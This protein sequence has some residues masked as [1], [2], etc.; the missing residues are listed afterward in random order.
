M[1]PMHRSIWFLTVLLSSLLS[2]GQSFGVA[3]D[4]APSGQAPSYLH[5]STT[6][7]IANAK[8]LASR[9][10][11]FETEI[12]QFS[13]HFFQFDPLWVDKDP[14][15]AQKDTFL[16]RVNIGTVAF[17]GRVDPRGDIKKVPEFNMATK[18]SL[19]LE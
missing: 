10:P 7:T 15:T 19:F 13:K 11:R 3:V 14:F 9:S 12:K 6:P 16:L 8:T 18:I 1:T 17:T 2:A 4:P 5:A